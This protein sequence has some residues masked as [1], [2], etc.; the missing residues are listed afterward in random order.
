MGG[1]VGVWVSG[2]VDGW[3]DRLVGGIGGGI[4]QG[5]LW[6]RGGMGNGWWVGYMDGWLG[7]WVGGCVG[8]WAMG[9]H[10][11]LDQPCLG[12]DMTGQ[13]ELNTP[14]PQFNPSRL[15]CA[16]SLHVQG[17]T[18]KAESTC[19]WHRA[20]LQIY[21][22]LT[23]NNKYINQS[24]V[25]EKSAKMV[26]RFFADFGK[27]CSHIVTKIEIWVD[28]TPISIYTK[29]QLSK[30]IRGRVNEDQNFK[31][32]HYSEVFEVIKLIFILQVHVQILNYIFKV[33]PWVLYRSWDI[34]KNVINIF[35][36]KFQNVVQNALLIHL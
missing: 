2:W 34:N 21:P 27:S 23:F 11:S 7:G 25:C 4:G 28:P 33:Q 20:D 32:V 19:P 10:T 3:V 16:I 31:G 9:S 13:G 5:L 8:G 26:V 15:I 35:T 22:W 29:N 24:L 6:P 12:T 30:L 1:W 14:S 36:P 17:G 18:L